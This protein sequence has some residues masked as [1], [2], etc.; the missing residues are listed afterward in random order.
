MTNRE[1]N[2]RTQLRGPSGLEYEALVRV[3]WDDQP[4]GPISV[5]GSIEDLGWRTYSTISEF[6]T[7]APDGTVE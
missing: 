7:M 6:F 4:N 5:G 3:H 2:L 1:K